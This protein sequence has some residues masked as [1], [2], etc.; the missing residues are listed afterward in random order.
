[1]HQKLSKSKKVI[2][3]PYGKN[4]WS[5]ML[6]NVNNKQHIATVTECYGKFVKTLQQKLKLQFYHKMSKSKKVKKLQK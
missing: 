4:I 3:K 5:K 1:M 6:I 2:K